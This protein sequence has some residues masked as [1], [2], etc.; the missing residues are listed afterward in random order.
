[1][2]SEEDIGA[3][4]VATYYRLLFRSPSSVRLLYDQ[5]AI[6]IR[7]PQKIKF[8]ICFQQK[9]EFNSFL[10]ND[11]IIKILSYNSYFIGEN[12]IVS[13]Y[14]TISNYTRNMTER[15]FTQQFILKKANSKYYICN[16]IFYNFGYQNDNNA[17]PKDNSIPVGLPLSQSPI[18]MGNPSL[19]P[20]SMPYGFPN[21]TLMN[22]VAPP[23]QYYQTPPQQ[24]MPIQTPISPMKA[25]PMTPP[26]YIPS[27]N[28]RTRVN[29]LDPDRTITVKGLS[30]SYNGKEVV[31][32]YS[33]FGK[34]TNQNF[35]HNT[36]YLEFETIDEADNAAQS[37][38]PSSI[39]QSIHVKVDKG[40]H[41]PKSYNGYRINK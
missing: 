38:I 14:G 33:K 29:D 27:S 4:F 6:I 25:K 21:S 28:G 7:E 32:A 26:S 13:V 39:P 15:L 30:H 23:T 41:T 17:F 20:A 35:T 10:E 5:H 9:F 8:Q 36:V 12:L 34:I 2:E 19:N 3:K 31:Q 24:Q 1:M 16:D 22:T 11:S 18:N 40:I 37:P